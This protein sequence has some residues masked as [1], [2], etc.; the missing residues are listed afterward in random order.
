MPRTYCMRAVR[1]YDQSVY[2]NRMALEKGDPIAERICLIITLTVSTDAV[3]AGETVCIHRRRHGWRMS[4]LPSAG[5]G[6][7]RQ[8]TRETWKVC[9]SCAN[10]MIRDRAPDQEVIRKELLP[11]PKPK[12]KPRGL[13]RKRTRRLGSEGH[14]SLLCSPLRQ[15]TSKNRGDR[16]QRCLQSQGLSRPV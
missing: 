6:Q 4:A 12:K 15:E 8:S 3:G 1:L 10:L 5:R 16:T 7:C 13:I 9:E 14:L 2:H 11:K